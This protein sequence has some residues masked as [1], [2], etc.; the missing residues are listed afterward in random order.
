MVLVLE[1]RFKFFQIIVSLASSPA[2]FKFC[3]FNCP[4]I[5]VEVVVGFSEN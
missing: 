2:V 4:I 5:R 1:E 3:W